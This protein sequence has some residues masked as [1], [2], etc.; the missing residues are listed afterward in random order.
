MPAHDSSRHVPTVVIGAGQ[1]GLSVSRCLTARGLEHVVLDRGTV[2]HSWRTQRWDSF[3]LLSPNWQ[4]RLPGYRY[5]GPEPDGFMTGAQV[6][7]FFEDYARSFAAPV[8]GGVTVRRVV[9]TAGGW[10]LDTT[11]GPLTATDV[12]VATGDLAHPSIPAAAADLPPDL[13]T[14]HTSAYRNPAQLPAG[15]VLVVGAG[16]SGQQIAAELAAS[17]RRVHLAVG[18][19][20]SLPRR[21]RGRDT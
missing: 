1:A 4:T 16:P 10:L 3:T 8:R 7:A 9:P 21:Y 19:H 15:A 12:V 11:S 18:R 17:G 13:V 20:R 6:V 5:R 14:L 2:A